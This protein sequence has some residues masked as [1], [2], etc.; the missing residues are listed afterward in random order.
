LSQVPWGPEGILLAIGGGTNATFSQMNM[1]DVYDLSSK[2]W[3][4]QSTDGPTPRYRVNPC[5]VVASASDGSSHNVYFFGGQNL[6][7]YAQQKQYD[8]MWILTIP[9]FKWIQVDQKDQ[10][11][12]PARAGHTCDIVGSQMVVVG[13]FVGD[14]L[15][16]DSP[17]IYVFDAS[18]LQWVTGYSAALGGFGSGNE[19]GAYKVP[20]SVISI[21]GGDGNGRATVTKPFKMP[22]PSGPIATGDPTQYKYTT[23][24]PAPTVHVTTGADG[25]VTTT[26]TT[27]SP[28]I[29]NDN[30]NGPKVG[31]IVGGVVGGLVLLTLLLLA[32]AY[33]LY[34]RKVSEFRYSSSVSTDFDKQDSS[35]H[36]GQ[37]NSISNNPSVVDLNELQGEPSFWGVLLSPRR[38]LRVVN[39]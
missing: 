25:S 1:V 30:P 39:R 21:V 9:A 37:R 8:D 2:D 17:G 3:T 15:S 18:K 38:S 23:F 36:R 35:F 13:G 27:P 14:Q 29:D 16:C 28:E 26:T 12:P 19:R 34:R 11:V 31:A 20:E 5:A 32:L 22:D 10:S 33:W 6:V 24:L 7:P 4:K